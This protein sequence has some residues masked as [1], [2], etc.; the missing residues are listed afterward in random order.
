MVSLFLARA[1]FERRICLA[2]PEDEQSAD[3]ES[4]LAES[5]VAQPFLE[6]HDRLSMVL[7]I[8]DNGIKAIRSGEHEIC[9]R[10]TA[11]LS[12][13]PATQGGDSRF[14][15]ERFLFTLVRCFHFTQPLFRC[16]HLYSLMN[17]SGAT[18]R[19]RYGP[20]LGSLTR[21]HT[22]LGSSTQARSSMPSDYSLFCGLIT[23]ARHRGDYEGARKAFSKATKSQI[24][25]PEMLW[26]AWLAFEHSHGTVGEIQDALDIVER[27][28][29][30]VEARR[31]QVL[32]PLPDSRSPC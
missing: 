28:R 11:H 26:E 8:L 22:S 3:A 4:P 12:T 1:G 24:D 20:R 32:I 5:A 15:L 23:S 31:A 17:S 29:A 25:W 7:D 18:R 21:L 10:R 9:V 19:Q 2:S 27:A 30:Q 16:R 6:P 14:R 13:G